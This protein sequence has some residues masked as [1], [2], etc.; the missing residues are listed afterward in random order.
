MAKC[1][2]SAIEEVF[3]GLHEYRRGDRGRSLSD[4]L[5]LLGMET[6]RQLW[7]T[8]AYGMELG[9]H[10]QYLLTHREE[11]VRFFCI[12]WNS[13]TT[14]CWENNSDLVGD[15]LSQKKTHHDGFSDHRPRRD[16][17]DDPNGSVWAADEGVP[18]GIN[19]RRHLT[20]IAIQ[21]GQDFSLTRNDGATVNRGLLLSCRTKWDI[22]LR[23]SISSREILGSRQGWQSG[24][25]SLLVSWEENGEKN[26]I[27]RN[28]WYTKRV[29]ERGKPIQEEKYLQKKRPSWGVFS[30]YRDFRKSFLRVRPATRRYRVTVSIPKNRNNLYKRCLIIEGVKKYLPPQGCFYISLHFI[31]GV[32]S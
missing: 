9:H 2:W 26:L 7:Q 32:A 31:K 25:I 20:L 30:F 17:T 8:E 19:R 27:S 14:L 22:L 12:S 5:A 23:R 18:E 28:I 15:H 10:H 24:S 13:D 16:L 6:P 3:V 11:I 21:N 29:L 1:F 4:P